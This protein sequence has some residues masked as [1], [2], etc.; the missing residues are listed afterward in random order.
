M[1]PTLEKGATDP[2]M[3]G[4]AEDSQ[5]GTAES[6][7]PTP[8]R[9]QCSWEERTVDEMPAPQEVHGG[10]QGTMYSWLRTDP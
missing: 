5:S 2:L 1:G 8:G 7:I 10:L 9:L 6:V 4:T 3:R